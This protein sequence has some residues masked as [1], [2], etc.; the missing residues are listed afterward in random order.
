[1]SKTRNLLLLM[2]LFYCT[3]AYGQTPVNFSLPHIS[4]QEGRDAVVEISAASAPGVLGV[5]VWVRYD[6][7]ILSPSSVTLSDG[8]SGMV[9]FNYEE[10][11]LLKISLALA[12]PQDI[13][14][15]LARITF[16]AIGSQG[17]V[18]A[19]H[20][21]KLVV[22][23]GL[24]AVTPQDGSVAIMA[25]EPPVLNP[26]PDQG[27]QAETGISLTVSGYDPNDDPLT[28][29]AENLPSGATLDSKSGAFHWTPA[30][31]DYYYITFIVSDG[32]K[33]ARQTVKFT[34]APAPPP[35]PP[36]GPPVFDP[37]PADF[38]VLPGQTFTHTFSAKDPNQDQVSYQASG[39]PANAGF[40]SGTG[41]L[42][43]TPGPEDS[44]LS[45]TITLEAA[46]P[47]GLASSLQFT[48]EVGFPN[49]PPEITGLPG[50]VTVAPGE[51]YRITVSGSDPD[52]DPL[53][54]SVGA[55]PPGAD[56]DPG[57]GEFSITPGSDQEG[58]I[59]TV[60]FTVTDPGGFSASA[61]LTIEV[62]TLN[63]PP[64]IVG[65]PQV[66]TV[67]PGEEYRITV[68]A[69]DPDGDPVTLSV[70]ALPPGADF[71][72]VSGDFSFTPDFN[73]G[74]QGFQV[75]FTAADPGG[76]SVTATL[77]LEVEKLNRAP[78]IGELPE[79]VTVFPGEE[80]R[81]T[82]TVSDPDGD[83]VTLS[84]DALPPGAD[85]D[86]VTGVFSFTP[87]ADQAGQS[88]QV[89]FT[90]ADPGGL[91]AAATLTV[92]VVQ[93]N[94]PPNISGVSGAVQVTPGEKTSLTF[95]VSDP[96]GD[97]PLTFSVSLLPQGA[98]FDPGTGVLS[99][100]PDF[101]QGGK[102][103]TVTIS[104]K[105]PE[106]LSAQI[107][108]ILD[109]PVL[110]RAPEFVDVP[111]NILVQ[112][113][114]EASFLVSVMDPDGDPVTPNLVSPLP[115][116]SAFDPATRIF[117]ITADFDQGGDTYQLDFEVADPGELSATWTVTLTVAKVNRPPVLLAPLENIKVDARDL[118]QFEV[119]AED[120]D[121][122]PLTFE[123]SGAPLDNGAT[124]DPAARQFEWQTT[125]ET[126]GNFPLE[127][128]VSDGQGG[129]QVAT[130]IITV[131][132]VN[133]P[134]A[135]DPIPD[136]HVI[137]D[138]SSLGFQVDATDPNGDP[139]AY[140]AQNL[141]SGAIFDPATRLFSYT[142]LPNTSGEFEV[143]FR[144][145]DG[146]LFDKL[147]VIIRVERPNLPP[148]IKPLPRTRIVIKPEHKLSFPVLA[149]DPGGETVALKAEGLPPGASFN[150]GNGMF[151]FTPAW[152]QRGEVYT[153]TFTAQDAGGL[154][155]PP[156]E[157]VI[158]VE[159]VN[160]DPVFDPVADYIV[161]EGEL[162][163]FTAAATD[164]DGD[165]LTYSVKGL[166][167]GASF[168]ETTGLFS[169]I[170]ESGR[171]GNIPVHFEV[172]DGRGGF[173]KEKANI[174]VGAVNRPPE[175][176]EISDKRVAELET[177]EFTVTASD[178]DEGDRVLVKAAPL[179]KGATFNYDPSTNSGVFKFTPGLG[180]AGTYKTEFEVS[181]GNL[182]TTMTVMIIVDPTYLPPVLTPI[183]DQTV[184]AEKKLRIKVTVKD[185]AR[186]EVTLSVDGL[187]D[188]AS[189]DR[190]RGL[191]TFEPDY[192]QLGDHQLTV[193]AVN[194]AELE[195]SETFTITV[196]G[197]NRPP[198]FDPLS[199]QSVVAGNLLELLVSVSDPDGDE[200]TISVAGRPIEELGATY[201][202][203]SGLLRWIPEPGLSGNFR[204]V[205]TADDE[206]GGLTRQAFTISVGAVNR[207]PVLDP[208]GNKQ[209][210]VGE[211]LDFDF[212]AADPDND[213]LKLTVVNRPQGAVVKFKQ[214][215]IPGTDEFDVG[216]G[217]FNWTPGVDQVGV[218]EVKLIVGD[219]NLSAEIVVLIEV[220][221]VNN[222][223]LIN[224]LGART[225]AEGAQLDIQITATDPDNDPLVLS[226]AN[227]PG[228]ARFDATT[229][230]FSFEPDHSQAGTYT[231]EFTATDPGDLFH[232]L[233][234]EITV[235]DLNR[236]PVL[237]ALK[238]QSLLAGD[239]LELTIAATDE[240]GDEL[241]ITIQGP[242]GIDFDEETGFLQWTP[243]A[244]DV[245]THQLTVAVT[246]GKGG[247]DSKTITFSVSSPEIEINK[248]PK[249]EPIGN[250]SVEVGETL[251][252]TVKAGDPDGDPIELFVEGLP[253]NATFDELSGDFSFTPAHDQEGEHKL[254]F[255]ASDGQLRAEIDVSIEVVRVENL[256]PV[257]SGVQDQQIEVGTPINLRITAEDPEGDNF[258]IQ[259]INLPEGASFNVSN[260]NFTYA[261]N[262]DQAGTYIIKFTSTDLLGA[263]SEAVMVVTV[264]GANRPPE[265]VPLSD[266]QTF[267]DSF[268]EF[269][270]AASDPDNDPLTFSSPN[271]ADLGASFNAETQVFSWTPTSPGTY[272]ANF[273]VDD[274]NGGKDETSALITV[275]DLQ[276]KVNSPP[277]FEE[278]QN[279]VIDAGGKVEFT[280][281]ASDPD[282]DVLAYTSRNLPENGSFD[283]AAL[284]FTFESSIDQAGAFLPVFTVSDG[285]L[286]DEITVEILVN[287][288]N[289]APAFNEIGDRSV[290]EGKTLHFFVT[291]QDPDG[292]QLVF[293][294][295][296]LPEHAHFNGKNGSFVFNTK[297]GQAGSY[298]ITF[299]CTDPEGLSDS[300][301]VNILVEEVNFP[302]KLDQVKNQSAVVGDLLEV[303]ISATDPND[304][305]SDLIFS[306]E[307]L[308][309]GASFS[310]TG[311]MF[312]WVP[313]A[314]QIGSFRVTFKVVDPGELN[315]EITIKITVTDPAREINSPPVLAQIG[316]KKVEENGTINFEVSAT[317]PD[318]GDVISLSVRGMPPGASF[319]TVDS[320]DQVKGTFS[321]T[322]NLLQGGVYSLTFSVTDGDYID[323]R[324]VNLTVKEL[325]VQPS[326]EVPGKQTAKLNEEMS[327]S[328]AGYDNS[329]E[330]VVL[331]VQNPPPNS[332]FFAATGLFSIT[333]GNEQAGKTY[334]VVFRVT[335]ASDN[336]VEASVDIEVEDV[337]RAPVFQHTPNQLVDMGNLLE[338]G[339]QADDPNGDPLTYSVEG[340]PGGA[341][342]DPE[343]RLF[344]WLPRQGEQGNYPVDFTVSDPDGLE[345]RMTVTVT[346]GGANR[347]PVIEPV[348]VP[349]VEENQ[350]VTFTV[351]ATDPDGDPITLTLDKGPQDAVFT[352]NGDGSGN[353]SWT[354][355]YDDAG[356]RKVHIVAADAENQ[357]R[358]V[359]QITVKN[360]NLQP[361]V[362]VRGGK[363]MLASAMKF[364][365]TGEGI[366]LAVDISEVL[367]FN[368]DEGDEIEVEIEVSDAGGDLLALSV[369]NLPENAYLDRE[370]SKVIFTP[371]F[372]Q[373]GQY[374]VLVEVT[375]G[376][377]TVT[378]YFAFDVAD[379]NRPP[380]LRPIGERY[381]QE[382][383]FIAFEI[384]ASDPDDDPITFSFSG[385]P[386]VATLVN[387]LFTFDTQ[388]LPPDLQV[389]AVR[390][391]F[392]A[393][394]GRGGE[395]S[396]ANDIAVIRSDSVSLA[397]GG[398][399][400]AAGM[401]SGQSFSVDIRDG[402]GMDVTLKNSTDGDV[403]VSGTFLVQE[404]SG[405][406]SEDVAQNLEQDKEIT[407][408]ASAG[409]EVP[410]AGVKKKATAKLI[411]ADGG[412]AAFFSIRRGWGLDIRRG[413][414]LDLSTTS[415]D[416]LSAD[417]S[418]N[419]DV[420]VAY[421]DS[422]LAVDL[423][424]IS[425][426][427]FQSNLVPA[428]WDSLVGGFVMLTGSVDTLTGTASFSIPLLDYSFLDT[429]FRG[430]PDTIFCGLDTIGGIDTLW[431]KVDTIVGGSDTL[432]IG[433]DTLVWGLDTLFCGPD[434]IF[435]GWDTL[436]SKPD[437]TE[438]TNTAFLA[439]LSMGPTQTETSATPST[440]YKLFTLGS[441]LD[442][443]PPSILVETGGFTTTDPG[444][445][446]I[447]A[448]V[449]DDLAGVK[450]CVVLYQVSGMIDTVSM[451]PK[452]GKYEGLIPR[453]EVGVLI[454]YFV[455][456]TDMQGNLTRDREFQIY[457]VSVPE[458]AQTDLDENGS[459]NIFDLLVFLAAWSIDDPGGDVNRDGEVDL[460]DLLTLLITLN[461]Q[462]GVKL[463][464]GGDDLETFIARSGLIKQPAEERSPFPD[465]FGLSINSRY[466]VS[467]AELVF[468]ISED[469]Q[470]GRV[471]LKVVDNTSLQMFYRLEGGTLRILV[472]TLEGKSLPLGTT[473]VEADYSTDQ[474]KPL[475]E[476]MIVLESIALG[477][478]EGHRL[479]GTVT[480]EGVML[481]PKSF[482][483]SQNYPNPFNP[484]TSIN[485]SIPDGEPVHVRLRIHNL[486][487]QLVKELVNETR[488]PGSYAVQWQGK[489]RRGRSVSS[490]VYF[491]RME[492]GPFV[493]TRKMVILK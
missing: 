226:A 120:P 13:T 189:F 304:P 340:L 345:D 430:W 320:P 29:R 171:R 360:V 492:A 57:T 246:D 429:I 366:R 378:E 143:T 318:P 188:N 291:G 77:T 444:P 255:S 73:Q 222:P 123:L 438:S 327:F 441:I 315:D 174:S 351:S 50:D 370:N 139:I 45:F 154:E 468:T 262:F 231:P 125:D 133:Q 293:S 346:V 341:S 432:V 156:E 333:P 43:Y 434:T 119:S 217:N 435:A 198:V 253:D 90:A 486:R 170:P 135:L 224:P 69:G 86:D 113:G 229:G 483:L 449:T 117:S 227:L 292:D 401:G 65:L 400:L 32:E 197:V 442:F 270:V 306:T 99:F 322:P 470:I 80:Y 21:E 195:T 273:E 76:L 436:Y 199:D 381:V 418:V 284:T 259:A 266:I 279:Y 96:D 51:E 406:I 342:F 12:S 257:I 426:S 145:S 176:S 84:V 332:L 163:E 398:A 211:E 62:K 207:P 42:T 221:A 283:P 431:G 46:D 452:N 312:S 97:E 489:N 200:L 75:T 88:F 471:N 181:D 349:E 484:S 395:D 55:L 373:A 243:E 417:D 369:R 362:K 476:K 248:P 130:I 397:P 339:V 98:S 268:V 216:Q 105:D 124:F 184:Y 298:D 41:E 116:N 263:S 389:E 202:P 357:T 390:F 276:V 423:P 25:N 138:G 330:N 415:M 413:W 296:E 405:P 286:S 331:S 230:L 210:L 260:G 446:R 122:D 152:E 234:V 361:E 70:G 91:S 421:Q 108:V 112:P 247:E 232:T 388:L 153:V 34:I 392:K 297:A 33:E 241:T 158:E 300:K 194:T 68:T 355:G 440:R 299:T 396:L 295:G 285:K 377:Y 403:D 53:T 288:V 144:A 205:I 85:F 303:A 179:P 466:Q 374:L 335:D 134:P 59:I 354:P 48:L 20:F 36:P 338:F 209:V 223:P 242:P 456:A 447:I 356:R 358:A 336:S 278:V 6:P 411:L 364:K 23:E 249:I 479:K 151:S 490:G 308:P 485:F 316:D 79:V 149:T 277:E 142:P 162:L 264:T 252:F 146:A 168:D 126:V 129:E 54:L 305:L 274:G 83:P 368:V 412:E 47:G 445:Y 465:V 379:V 121:G 422:D 38:K 317:D 155:A 141:P 472:F 203:T 159:D 9:E 30:S 319:V 416:S 294:T 365:F 464:S 326:I 173:D 19:L 328:V 22:N 314:G 111:A 240:D 478:L 386:G 371:D 325:D 269:M 493:Q 136:Q 311:R 219:K 467:A 106:G 238:N 307:G 321:F 301:T 272:R 453:Q 287:R 208:V 109:V 212:S 101:G 220:I 66:V 110:N 407:L 353:F 35:P 383:K 281:S 244:G 180:Q 487:G 132:A 258:T 206:Q 115:P 39:L 177:L 459:V 348:A 491:Y 165:P 394:D 191:L 172:N 104:V 323:E 302:P 271:A 44:G 228:N 193:K 414:G 178:P 89:T 95:T 186:L 161:L 256:P 350:E 72:P 399:I 56:F 344:R 167:E 387:N 82:V 384:N 8:L 280:V 81:I 375:D 275:N 127:I 460:W 93:P 157:V 410:E 329:S 150:A 17:Q 380:E 289:Q 87:G 448:E 7:T 402:I 463:S 393:S 92:E 3:W 74:G 372:D 225:I 5:D 428:A 352:D 107:T 425:T 424:G 482:A 182:S 451:T 16:S 261:P 477:D 475:T 363:K 218:H 204:M 267:V 480:L 385:L 251:S 169:W 433:T 196:L 31:A 18:S 481:L 250:S 439:G 461:E 282:G 437:T 60:T 359:V 469:L 131:G 164:P 67:I 245:G 239:L 473:L 175:L 14:G 114:E 128:K 148:E 313:A 265:F 71:D 192:E 310:P 64:E 290:P 420:T 102:S 454:N 58:E 457:V 236:P 235:T 160:R 367:T 427:S 201:E 458:T 4:V 185:P 183:G 334:T 140:S 309:E 462:A 343:T 187:P 254:T 52:G 347:P 408:L 100:T 190:V 94:R 214:D 11:G 213:K 391:V 488:E 61:S 2:F 147:I 324:Q 409:K 443:T 376:F 118:V 455:E 215:P 404:I 10:A 337:N 24:I 166:P 27:G 103:F 474:D 63:K 233:S 37:V 78:G 28:F 237:G 49:R 40:N 450:T 15:N 419:L 382:G 137:S 1:M 26:I